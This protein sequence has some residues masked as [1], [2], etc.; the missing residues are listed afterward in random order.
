MGLFSKDIQTM[1]D[2]YLHTLEDIYYAEQ[3]IEK[4]LPK[5]IDKAS[6]SALKEAF[7][8]HLEET[9]GHLE[10]L[11]KVFELLDEKPQGAQCPAIDDH[12]G[13]R[14]DFEGNWR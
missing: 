13:K 7:K 11:E 12:Q 2:L 6:S 10:R 8:H 9:K 14:A 5:M 1:D 3:Q 4:E